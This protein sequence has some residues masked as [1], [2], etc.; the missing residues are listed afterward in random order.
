MTTNSP[1]WR[2]DYYPPTTAL[3]GDLSHDP[4]AVIVDKG[5]HANG[6]ANLRTLKFVNEHAH[7]TKDSALATLGLERV[8]EWSSAGINGGGSYCTVRQ[9]LPPA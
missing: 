5:T 9:T 3:Y 2:A 4:G 8:T 6:S 7:A 1:E